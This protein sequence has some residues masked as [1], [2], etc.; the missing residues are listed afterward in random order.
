MFLILARW[1]NK[2]K[3]ES[4]I[5]QA[6]MLHAHLAYIYRDVEYDDLNPKIVFTSLACQIY[7]FNNF[8]YDI[9]I[10]PEF[11]GSA[12]TKKLRKEAEKE[13]GRYML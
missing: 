12:S 2:S 5:S 4:S 13:V 6:C 10:D 7:L 3:K 9:D 11:Y 1:I 8:K